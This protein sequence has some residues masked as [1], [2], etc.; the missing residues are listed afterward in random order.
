L[1]EYLRLQIENP[2]LLQIMILTSQFVT[3][4]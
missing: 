2:I 3:S 4:K 1:G